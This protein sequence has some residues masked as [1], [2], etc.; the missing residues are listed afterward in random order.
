MIFN[1][2]LFILSPLKVYVARTWQHW[3]GRDTR[4]RDKL[5]KIHT[6]HVSDTFRTRY[7]FM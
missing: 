4:T 6:T 5:F 3:N 7:S 2:Q 1:C